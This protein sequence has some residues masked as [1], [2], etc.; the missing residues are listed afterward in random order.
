MG[1]S[2]SHWL[3]LSRQLPLAGRSD[4][5]FG[6]WDRR[7]GPYPRGP[8]MH[9]WKGVGFQSLSPAWHL[10]ADSQCGW[11]R[12]KPQHW[13]P[14][15]P[16]ILSGPREKA[17]RLQRGLKAALPSSS[18]SLALQSPLDQPYSSQQRGNS[19]RLWVGWGHVAR[20][21]PRP[22]ERSGLPDA[23][24]SAL[25]SAGA[26]PVRAVQPNPEK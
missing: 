14:S 21:T 11:F 7:P 16:V 9:F 3:P 25:G 5:E 22:R 23:A 10:A 26:S 1:P 15:S 17:F 24:P 6:V 8:S 18:N 2:K 19:S 20:R 12:G 13:R 4:R